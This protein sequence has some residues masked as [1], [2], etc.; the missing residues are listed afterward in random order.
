MSFVKLFGYGMWEKESIIDAQCRQEHPNP[1]VHRSSGKLGKPRVPLEWWT[2]GLGLNTSDGHYLSH[3]I[4]SLWSHVADH[5]ASCGS[6]DGS[7]GL[8]QLC[9]PRPC[10][11]YKWGKWAYTLKQYFYHLFNKGHTL[12]RCCLSGPVRSQSIIQIWFIYD[13]CPGCNHNSKFSKYQGLEFIWACC[14]VRVEVMKNFRI[15]ASDK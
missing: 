8:M 11:V 12:Q 6:P 10:K 13:P 7:L 9:L 14:H 5:R 4:S 3:T 1:R 2:L 15:S